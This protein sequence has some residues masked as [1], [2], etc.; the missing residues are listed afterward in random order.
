MDKYYVVGDTHGNVS[1]AAAVMRAAEHNGIHHIF[2]V[3]D[4]GIWDHKE[5]GVY[6]LDK[7]SELA[8]LRDVHWWVTLGNHENY[9]SVERYQAS[10]QGSFIK[11]RDRITILGNKSGMFELDGIKFAS[12]GGAYS[13]DRFSREP[14]ISWWE[15]EMTTM[16]DIYRLEEL[17]K[18]HG[19]ADVLLTHDAPTSL[20]EWPGFIKDDPA[21]DAN[22]KM[23]DTA[24]EIARPTLWFHGH[25][26]RALDYKHNETYV[27][28][29]G[30]DDQAM[31]YTIPKRQWGSVALL[32]NDEGTLTYARDNDWTWV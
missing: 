6:Y 32:T 12:V 22:R 8:E 14:G 19:K 15:Q 28:G 30:A 25:Y 31:P 7:I 5:G 16:A 20:P 11:V 2:Q 29:L 17:V 23:M 3:G 13:I 21:S 26:H 24:W 4:F 18:V 27:I 1:F 10:S 9:D